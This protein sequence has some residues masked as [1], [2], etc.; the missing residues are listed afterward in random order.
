[1]TVWQKFPKG[2]QYVFCVQEGYAKFVGEILV[3]RGFDDVRYLTGG[4]KTWGNLLI[5]KTV[6]EG[7]DYNLFQLFIRPGKASCSYGLCSGAEMMI[8]DPSR[9][10]DFYLDFA[11][12]KNSTIIKTFE[13]HLQADYISG[14]RQIAG[15]TSADFFGGI[16]FDGTK[17]PCVKIVVGKAG[18]P[19]CGA[20]VEQEKE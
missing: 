4:I 14:S 6:C 10:V 13:T 1:M 20:G 18:M 9:N 12:N 3:K 15:Q 17:A 2:V 8:V 19:V 16:D 5:P 7:D 11:K